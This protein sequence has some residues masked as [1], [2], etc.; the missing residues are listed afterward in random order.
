MSNENQDKPPADVIDR[1]RRARPLGSPDTPPSPPTTPPSSASSTMENKTRRNFIPIPSE[2]DSWFKDN[3][4]KNAS[5]YRHLLLSQGYRSE[6][7]EDWLQQIPNNQVISPPPL[8]T[9]ESDRNRVL[10]EGGSEADAEEFA[11]RPDTSRQFEYESQ[12]PGGIGGILGAAVDSGNRDAANFINPPSASVGRDPSIPSVPNNNLSGGGPDSSIIPTG[13]GGIKPPDGGGRT[14]FFDDAGDESQKEFQRLVQEYFKTKSFEELQSDLDSWSSKRLLDSAGREYLRLLETTEQYYLFEA[15]RSGLFRSINRKLENI[16]IQLEEGIKIGSDEIEDAIL[17]LRNE[18]QEAVFST[19]RRGKKSKF[20]GIRKYYWENALQQI[21]DETNKNAGFEVE[22]LPKIPGLWNLEEAKARIIERKKE[23]ERVQLELKEKERAERI[24]SIRNLPSYVPDPYNPGEISFMGIEGHRDTKLRTWVNESKVRISE[25]DQKLRMGNLSEEEKKSKEK[26]RKEVISSV[27]EEFTSAVRTYINFVESLVPPKTPL[28]LDMISQEIARIERAISTAISEF[29]LSPELE[30]DKD[31]G[32]QLKNL[33]EGRLYYFAATRSGQSF[34]FKDQMAI[35]QAVGARGKELFSA[36]YKDMDRMVEQI[37]GYLEE[38]DGIHYRP[39]TWTEQEKRDFIDAL[40]QESGGDEPH[41]KIV[42]K[43]WN[44]VFAEYAQSR[45]DVRD[46]ITEKRRQTRIESIN[47]TRRQKGQAE[48]TEQEAS[49]VFLLPYETAWEYSTDEEAEAKEFIEENRAQIFEDFLAELLVDAEVLRAKNRDRFI[50]LDKARI[51]SEVFKERRKNLKIPEGY[52]QEEAED[53]LMKRIESGMNATENMLGAHGIDSRYGGMRIQFY[54]RDEQ[55]NYIKDA[56]GNFVRERAVVFERAVL[57]EFHWL[58]DNDQEV[59]TEL[60]KFFTIN[61]EFRK[62]FFEMIT[63][64]YG[65]DPK[66]W[67][68]PNYSFYLAY[69]DGLQVEHFSLPNGDVVPVQ[70]ALNMQERIWEV[71]QTA[72]ANI[73]Q[74]VWD[75]LPGITKEGSVRSDSQLQRPERPLANVWYAEGGG[76]TAARRN[77]DKFG[78]EIFR[79]IGTPWTFGGGTKETEGGFVAY[80]LMPKILETYWTDFALEMGAANL[81]QLYW[82]YNNEWT[83]SADTLQWALRG[84]MADDIRNVLVGGK[85]GDQEFKGLIYSPFDKGNLRKSS[86]AYF[87]TDKAMV[88]R[89]KDAS[90]LQGMESGSGNFDLVLSEAIKFMGILKQ[91]LTVGDRTRNIRTSK[92]MMTNV[93][94]ELVVYLGDG[95]EELFNG[96]YF[97][98]YDLVSPKYPGKEPRKLQQ[99]LLDVKG[100]KVAQILPGETRAIMF[101][102]KEQGLLGGRFKDIINSSRSEIKL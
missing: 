14:S 56:N 68:P 71:Y 91:H 16:Y 23:E 55:G 17:Q 85:V 1:F 78:H 77:M 33:V 41:N 95:A 73:R 22:D 90:T 82:R 101:W 32:I 80:G 42:K 26:E 88:S 74:Y 53:L 46:Q 38:D 62:D 25:I 28:S 81:Q 100:A 70:Q 19:S 10:T 18:D 24:K 89:A 92:F 11:S 2:I 47:E 79:G 6:E 54:K 9:V 83:I 37:S 4:G 36:V 5:E 67:L 60:E 34:K 7:V 27:K 13:G 44:K 8:A 49:R 61:G 75:S 84:A 57:N 93:G 45:K 102:V 30:I 35:M 51:L 87:S 97:Y 96:G 63:G 31:V 58:I 94:G 29:N 40:L 69:D 12:R 65:T 20:A 72:K 3:P 59:R 76:F 15:E 48:L 86:M 21:L 64:R 99:Q 66:K 52:T 39:D 43:A 50:D 98:V